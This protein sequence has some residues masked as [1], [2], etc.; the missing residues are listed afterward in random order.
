MSF[1]AYFKEEFQVIQERDPGD[2]FSHGSLA[3]SFISCY[4]E[5]QTGAQAI[6]ERPLLS[7]QVDFT[8]GSEKTG[9]ETIRVRRSERDCLLIMVLV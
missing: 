9:I 8:A 5:V 3:V 4:A 1:F 2:T 6:S 7:G